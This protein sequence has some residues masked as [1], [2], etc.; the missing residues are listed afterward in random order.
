MGMQRINVNDP[1]GVLTFH[2]DQGTHTVVFDMTVVK[3]SWLVEFINSVDI[4]S[5]AISG[6][7]H[8]D[9]VALAIGMYDVPLSLMFDETISSIKELNDRT[10][11]QIIRYRMDREEVGE[12]TDD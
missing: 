3:Q 1:S 11:S 8:D 10:L 7:M 4:H 5:K 9:L 12:K 2:I 6:N